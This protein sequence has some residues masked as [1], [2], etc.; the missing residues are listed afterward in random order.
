MTIDSIIVLFN[1]NTDTAEENIRNIANQVD[2]LYL[3]DNSSVAYNKRFA[4]IKNV[5]YL[6]QYKNLGI[7]AAQNIGIKKALVKR[8]DFIFFADPDSL[9][10]G[11]AVN[12]L[13]KKY[14]QLTKSLS[15]I[16]GICPSAFNQ[17]TNLPIS[18]KGNLI[19]EIQA[20]NVTEVTFMMNSGSLIP[21]KFFADAGLMWEDL[22]IDDVDCE[23]CWRATKKLKVHFFQ[24]NEISIKHSLGNNTRKVGGKARSLASPNRL[25]YQFRNFIWVLREGYAPR[26][27][28]IY[29]GEKYLIKMFYF[30]L[31][32]KPR[33]KNLKN[34]SHG[35]YKGIFKT[36]TMPLVGFSEI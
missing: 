6:P 19:K 27:W 29:N 30:P 16:G 7:A 33:M 11:D 15:K 21:T 9:F 24:D 23:W 26:Q 14:E 18:L 22:F 32:V 4:N 25:F 12:K 13:H 10:P 36:P 3:I 17:T 28:L 31:F 2:T 35:I 5:E 34:I 20:Y 8:A 1:D